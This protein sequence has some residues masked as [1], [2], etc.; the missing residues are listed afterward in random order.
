MAEMNTLLI[1][2]LDYNATVFVNGEQVGTH[3]GPDVQARI[4]GPLSA[5]LRPC[6]RSQSW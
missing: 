2:G 4:R 6:E 1:D 3:V 5:R